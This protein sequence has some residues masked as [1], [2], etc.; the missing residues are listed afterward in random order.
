MM[1][2]PEPMMRT[3]EGLAMTRSIG[4]KALQAWHAVEVGIHSEELEVILER[5]RSDEEV[6]EGCGLTL[7]AQIEREPGRAQPGP[8][9]R[10][11][12][13]KSGQVSGQLSI[14]GL[15]PGAL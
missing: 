13:V 15:I 5:D 9:V 2:G 10:F 3:L 4:R 14:R 1:I 12:I 8:E 6:G 7:L 11:Q